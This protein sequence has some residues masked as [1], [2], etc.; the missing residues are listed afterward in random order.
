MDLKKPVITRK[1]LSEFHPGLRDFLA[2]RR[3]GA[4]AFS[5]NRIG[6][7][8][9]KAVGKTEGYAGTPQH[10]HVLEFQMVYVLK[11]SV[12]FKIGDDVIKVTE[13]D[14]L[15]LPPSI[16]HSQIAYSE[17]VEMLEI[18]CPADFETH[19]L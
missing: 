6:I 8:H 11:G 15:I 1:S 3:F 13:G 18:T 2:Y 7:Q 16:A 4:E 17:D 19:D 14:S 12:S 5:D 10:M 9:I